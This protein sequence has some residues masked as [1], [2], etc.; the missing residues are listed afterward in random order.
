MLHAIAACSFLSAQKYLVSDIPENLKKGADA[1]IRE[2]SELYTVKSVNAM[3]VITKQATTIM[4]RSGEEHSYV[5]IP[6]NPTTKVSDIKVVVYD[7]NGVEKK[8]Y[9][10]KDFGDFTHNSN[11]ALYVED[12]I[13]VLK[14]GY[15]KYPYTVEY[16]YETSTSNTVYLNSL[17]PINAFDVSLQNAELKIINN[18][19]LKLRSK[20]LN[21]TYGTVNKSENGTTSSYSYSGIPA[22]KHQDLAP[23]IKA[24]APRVEF[25]L[26]NFSLANSQG[27]L[28]SWDNFGKWYNTLLKPVSVVTPEIKKE[29]DALNLTGSTKQKVKTLYQYMQNKTRYVF[30]AMGIGGWQPMPAEE[31]SK[32][33]YG[34]CKGLTNYMRTL[35]DAAGIPS[36]YA[37]I[38]D[39]PTEFK[40]DKDFPKL[41]G[42]HVILMVPTEDGPIWLENTS[43]LMAFNHLSYTSHNRNV[44]AIK[45]NGVE[46]IDTPVYKPED[47]KEILNAEIN[48]HPELGITSNVK[49]EYSGGQYDQNIHLVTKKNEELKSYMK[50]NFY[51]IKFAEVS[52][53]DLKNDRDNA[54]VSYNL[55]FKAK[56]FSKKLGNDLFFPVMPFYRSRPLV[57][58]EERVLPFETTFPLEDD[59]TLKYIAPEG[60]SFSE[61][62]TSVEFSSEFGKYKMSFQQ[63]GNT[64]T[65]HRVL[66]INKGSYPKEKYK[67]YV[68]FRKKTSY[69][70]S[71]KII[72]AKK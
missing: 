1:V 69:N 39:N 15:D 18:S 56:D 5:Y 48:L 53:N 54:K 51:G 7:E 22:F 12:R 65:V 32:K 66:T 52:V 29:V 8:K 36:Y 9:S 60:Y 30:I 59:Y 20:A 61:V 24:L 14:P 13:L 49:F 44:L 68:A 62:P 37:V 21:T 27:D 47:S 19:G 42:N 40:F 70:D 72:L 63:Q 71:A 58:N 46:L 11:G 34:D 55:D 64:L 41:D 10:K 43:Q 57:E 23:S 33:G 26:E 50:D 31:V 67:D 38:Y 2:S 4:D 25:A 16:T 35:L 28:S 17:N 3:T 45:N 6:Y